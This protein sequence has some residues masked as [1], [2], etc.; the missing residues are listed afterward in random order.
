MPLLR[1][2]QIDEDTKLG[3]WQ[4][5]EAE[6]FFLEKADINRNIH[7]PHKRLQHLAGRYL[8]QELFPDFPLDNILI[9]DSR[10]PYLHP[11]H[12]YFS[13]AHCGERAAAIVSKTKK[14][15][16]DIENYSPKI[17]RVAAKF[18]N[19]WELE[20][21]AAQSSLELQT[22]CW[23][24]KEAIYK[25]YG[26]GGVDFR[27]NILLKPFALQKVGLIDALFIK[28]ATEHPL[29]LNYVLRDNYCYA[30]LTDDYLP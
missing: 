11:Q 27:D 13:I 29:Q 9:Q 26:D 15:G 3:I 28:N 5:A 14:V 20:S 8:L 30:W 18:L 6:S 23:C 10:K 2:I 17:R 16:V 19:S 7:H 25:W 21:F 22:V 4:I 12:Y 1:T 24:A